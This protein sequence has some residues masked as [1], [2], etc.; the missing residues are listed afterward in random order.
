MELLLLALI[1]LY[2]FGH[3]DQGQR[4]LAQLTDS[5]TDRPDGAKHTLSDLIRFFG[6]RPYGSDK[7]ARSP[8]GHH[9]TQH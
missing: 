9:S 4:Q 3:I 1:A 8:E 7:R 2:I 5:G 6:K